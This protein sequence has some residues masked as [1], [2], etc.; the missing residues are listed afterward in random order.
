VKLMDDKYKS[1][2]I[3]KIGADSSKLGEWLVDIG[4]AITMYDKYWT[5]LK[6]SK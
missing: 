5:E 4:D 3:L 6:A 1:D 2:P